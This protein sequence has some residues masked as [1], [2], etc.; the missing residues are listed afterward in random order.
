[1]KIKLIKCSDLQVEFQVVILNLAR[2]KA[3]F[4]ENIVKKINLEDPT[5]DLS[6]ELLPMYQ[7]AVIKMAVTDAIDK[8]ANK[9]PAIRKDGEIFLYKHFIKFIK[10]SAPNVNRIST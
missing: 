8:M 5:V 10:L 6:D 4:S 9:I 2:R 1:M 7:A 3:V